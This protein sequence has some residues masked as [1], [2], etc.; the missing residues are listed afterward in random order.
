MQARI[1]LREWE[2]QNYRKLYLSKYRLQ[3]FILQIIRFAAEQ[4]SILAFVLWILS[5]MLIAFAWAIFVGPR[6]VRN[7]EPGQVPQDV[8]QFENQIGGGLWK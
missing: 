4:L 2:H 7:L 6:M 1:R 5:K 8:H 3:K